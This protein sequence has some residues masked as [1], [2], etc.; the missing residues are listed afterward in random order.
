MFIQGCC[1]VF[2]GDSSSHLTVFL[3]E[4]VQRQRGRSPHGCSE[5]LSQT[6]TQSHVHSPFSS[7]TSMLA[8]FSYCQV[9]GMCSCVFCCRLSRLCPCQFA[10]SWMGYSGPGHGILSLAVSEKYLWCL[11]YK[12]GLFCSALPG[13]GLRWQKFEDAVQQ[14]AV[15][16]SGLP[17][18]PCA[19]S[20][21][22]PTQPPEHSVRADLAFPAG[23]RAFLHGTWTASF[24]ITGNCV[25]AV[26]F[27]VFFIN[28]SG[29]T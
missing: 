27:L 14:V 10:E 6:H 9:W 2:A 7:T 22:H 15:S 26:Q 5:G 4:L 17:L 29:N 8:H 20:P 18:A 13:A 19:R 11:D 28:C 25:N 16:P 24:D 21:P 3:L 1:G 12:G 23:L